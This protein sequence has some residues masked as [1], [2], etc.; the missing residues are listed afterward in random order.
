MAR[1]KSPSRTGA[2]PAQLAGVQ[3]LREARVRPAR[4]QSLAQ[5]MDRALHQAAALRQSVGGCAAAWASVVP[6]ELLSRTAL[7]GV[8]RAV[9]TVRVPDAST[10]FELD[11]FLRAGGER[12]VVTASRS[13][14]GRIRLVVGH[15]SDR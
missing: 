3:R 13:T 15:L 8:S 1:S 2:S 6:P 9:L 11:R 4:D 7:E 5:D 14:V 12:A 10:R